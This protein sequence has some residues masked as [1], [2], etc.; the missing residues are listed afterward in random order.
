[1][2]RVWIL[3]AMF[4]M[5]IVLV[6]CGK[7]DTIIDNQ[8]TYVIHQGEP[9]SIQALS[10]E[11]K[12]NT[13]TV[14]GYPITG[15]QDFGWDIRMSLYRVHPDGRKERVD[16]AWVVDPPELGFWERE[17]E[18][19]VNEIFTTNSGIGKIKA[20]IAEDDTYA[21]RDIV[22]YDVATISSVPDQFSMKP[23]VIHPNFI[24]FSP[25]IEG[26][27]ITFD[28]LRL[29]GEIYEPVQCWSLQEI[30]DI[31]QE[32]YDTECS[33]RKWPFVVKTKE[34]YYAKIIFGASL[35]NPDVGFASY[36]Y[37]YLEKNSTTEFAY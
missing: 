19:W 2:K 36:I 35:V 18:I 32:G 8:Y 20:Y 34:G 37:Y 22:V 9:I 27:D 13:D 3:L 24:D 31:P 28:G 16:A 33:Y 5:F 14:Y 26:A 25:E 1:M 30:T 7:K 11:Y 4:L 29:I 17:D 12:I 21:E 6:G 10:G 15:N 23:G